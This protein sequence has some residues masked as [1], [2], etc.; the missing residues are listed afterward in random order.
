MWHVQQVSGMWPRPSL[1]HNYPA[2]HMHP[3]RFPW[4]PPS[5][6]LCQCPSYSGCLSLLGLKWNTTGGHWCQASCVTTEDPYD[7]IWNVRKCIPH[8][9]HL[10]REVHLIYL[11]SDSLSFYQP[12]GKW[13]QND[14]RP[15]H[16]ASCLYLL[17]ILF[18]YILATLGFYLP[19]KSLAL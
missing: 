11:L 17:H 18:Y 5:F 8:R 12:L 9:Q 10:S 4:L 2:Y 3:C 7:V 13:Q 19:N 6:S 14:K 15:N 1:E 16:T